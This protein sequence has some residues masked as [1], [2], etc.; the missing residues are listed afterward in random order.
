MTREEAIEMW[1]I[2]ALENIWNEK[3]CNEILD[4]LEQDQWIPVSE[5][6][7]AE[8]GE[9]YLVCYDDGTIRIRQLY[10]TVVDNEPYFEYGQG[11]VAWMPLPKPAGAEGSEE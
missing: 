8:E 7:P 10:F 6:Y 4:A 5:R 2:P 11:V 3:K 9:E 1:V